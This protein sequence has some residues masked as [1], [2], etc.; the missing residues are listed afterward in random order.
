MV[1][2]AS[3]GNSAPIDAKAVVDQFQ[4]MVRRD[5]GVLSLLGVEEGV[6]RVGYR[7]G[8]D[9]TCENGACVMPH[10]E[11]QEL[12]NETVARREPAMRV[13]VQLVS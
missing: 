13:V 9:P 12:M 1:G 11:L 5:G 10:L 4:H 2:I 6:M 7:P 8:A 3:E